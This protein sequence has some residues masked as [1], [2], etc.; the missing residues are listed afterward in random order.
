MGSHPCVAHAKNSLRWRLVILLFQRPREIAVQVPRTVSKETLTYVQHAWQKGRPPTRSSR[1]SC[2]FREKKVKSFLFRQCSSVSD[3]AA[4]AAGSFPSNWPR[5]CRRRQG[6]CDMIR[7][8][9]TTLKC[10]F[11]RFARDLSRLRCCLMP[12]T[13]LVLVT[14][15]FSNGYLLWH[16][17][18]NSTMAAARVASGNGITYQ[19]VDQNLAY[20]IGDTKESYR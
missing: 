3:G 11:S 15:V 10:L 2:A 4:Q 17:Q 12:G 14:R 7:T 20:S 1:M 13:R 9:E 6:S 5:R 16:G 19:V 8:S 18:T